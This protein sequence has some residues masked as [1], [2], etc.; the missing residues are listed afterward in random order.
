MKIAG[1]IIVSSKSS[2][3]LLLPISLCP[4]PCLSHIRDDDQ[5]EEDEQNEH[6][7]L[8]DSIKKVVLPPLL[9]DEDAEEEFD[10]FLLDAAQWL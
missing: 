1:E 4:D 6:P 7:A 9:S 3:N 8:K 10:T 5:K 2:E